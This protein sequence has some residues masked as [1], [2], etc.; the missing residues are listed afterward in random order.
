MFGIALGLNEPG[1]FIG[2]GLNVGALRKAVGFL[3]GFGRIAAPQLFAELDAAALGARI[4]GERLDAM[5]HLVQLLG[6]VQAPELLAALEQKE[7]QM[8]QDLTESALALLNIDPIHADSLWQGTF[9][10]LKSPV[11]PQQLGAGAIVRAV[12]SKSK[13]KPNE[14]LLDKTGTQPAGGANILF[15]ATTGGDKVVQAG[16]TKSVLVLDNTTGM[17]APEHIFVD[18][19]EVEVL[20]EASPNITLK[21]PLKMDPTIG[22]AVLRGFRVTLKILA[23]DGV[24]ARSDGFWWLFVTVPGQSRQP[25]LY[26]RLDVLGTPT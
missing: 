12:L 6:A 2:L 19:E 4:Q 9:S 24:E 11:E 16:S 17:A 7:G 23:T 1:A 14:T 15:E 20:S 18:G 13:E 8:R 21:K 5:L 3:R 22:G 10:I 26:G 25:W